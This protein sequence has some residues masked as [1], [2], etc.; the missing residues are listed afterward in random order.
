[1]RKF[2]EK[3]KSAWVKCNTKSLYL[4]EHRLSDIITAIQLMGSYQYAGRKAVDWGKY[5]GRQPKSAPNWDTIFSDHP[6]FFLIKDDLAFLVWRRSSSVMIHLQNGN[7]I[8]S[9]KYLV[10]E[11][12]KKK[13]Y[14]WP[15]LENDQIEVLIHSAIRMHSC[16]IETNKDKRWALPIFVAVVVVFGTL[17][18][19]L[20]GAMLN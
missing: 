5:I 15:P 11:K 2:I 18:G 13:E 8:V 16:A 12:D 17:T 19:T 20:L 14:S 4:T 1:M 10:L 6:E 7:K 3:V 9:K